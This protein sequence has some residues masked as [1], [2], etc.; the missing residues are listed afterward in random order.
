[1]INVNF[2]P[3]NAKPRNTKPSC[4][5]AGNECGSVSTVHCVECA[6]AGGHWILAGPTQPK[7]KSTYTVCSVVCV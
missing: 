4:S 7:A 1:M 3:M 2:Q 6:W 5:P